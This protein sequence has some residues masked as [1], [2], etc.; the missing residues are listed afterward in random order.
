RSHPLS[1]LVA[2]KTYAQGHGVRGGSTWT[3]VK[4]V[5]DALDAAFYLA[6]GA[7]EPAGK[8][9]LLAL[10]V[11]GSMGT[12][13]VAGS[14]LTPREGSA[15]MALVAAATEPSHHVVGFTGRGFRVTS[16]PSRQ[17]AWAGYPSSGAG[18]EP[19]AISHRQRVDEVVRDIEGLPMGPTDCALPM[20]Y[21]LEQKL[22][23]DVFVVYTDSET[24]HGEVH[25][26]QA[27]RQY[28]EKTG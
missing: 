11:S 19:L 8:R 9:W 14:P 28:R 4:Q 24:W 25:P 22:A 20:V 23:V 3:P 6:F 13:Q 5:V 16:A 10:D 1:L 7:V 12:G 26:F 2:L 18:V 15:A 21:A 17:G 27:L